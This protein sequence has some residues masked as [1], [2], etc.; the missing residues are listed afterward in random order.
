MISVEEVKAFLQSAGSDYSD[1]QIAESITLAVNRTKKLL[2]TEDLPETPE[3][4]RA[5]LYLAVAELASHVNLFYRKDGGEYLR[6]KDLVSEA[7]R[8]LKVVPRGGYMR[9]Q[10]I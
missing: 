9:W 10:T 6:V 4:K 5:L 3:V 8:L 1:E 2:R 7:E